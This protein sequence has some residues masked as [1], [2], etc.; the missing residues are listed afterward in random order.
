MTRLVDR[1][2]DHPAVAIWGVNLGPS[3]EN[4]YGIPYV[5]TMF[6]QNAPEIDFRTAMTDY[7]ELAKENF[8][9]WLED[10]YGNINKLNNAWETDY[11]SFDE[12]VLPQPIQTSAQDT[13][14]KNGDS[15]SSMLDWQQFRYDMLLDEWKFI[16]NV[17]KELDPNKAILG[18]P[19]WNPTWKQ[20]GTE[21]MCGTAEYVVESNLTEIHRANWNIVPSDNLKFNGEG[22]PGTGTDY[23]NYIEY[24]RKN[25]TP[26]IVV[27]ENWF[28][29]GFGND[30][31][32][33]RSLEVRDY[34]RDN[35]GYMWFVVS[36]SFDNNKPNW[37]WEN[38]K[39]VVENSKVNEFENLT[40]KNP[41]LLFYY[42][43]K[44]LMSHYYEEKDDMRSN[45][46]YYAISEALF[47]ANDKKL[48]NS[49]ISAT[50][51]SK[52]ALSYP[53]AKVL[54]MANQRVISEDVLKELKKFIADGGKIILIGSNGV[55]NEDF[56]KDTTVIEELSGLDDEQI[57]ERFYTWGLAEDAK[58]PIISVT[59][60]GTEYAE[61]PFY[62]E[63]KEN[64]SIFIKAIGNSLGL[65]SDGELV[66]GE[67]TLENTGKCGDNVCDENET[68]NIG[69]CPQDCKEST[70]MGAVNLSSNSDQGK[71]G[72]GICDEY[73][74]Q[75][76]QVCP[77]DCD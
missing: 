50:Q 61:I 75:N 26:F 23:A 63:A 68:K 35:G 25:N 49:F 8:H 37:S 43:M 9:I 3:G 70:E 72:D 39:E 1:Y 31:P 56:E 57:I 19:G 55:F 15:R 53:E 29:R 52:S 2:K 17:V 30:I 48:Q 18:D 22:T 59:K 58:M 71:C 4:G 16:V 10:K 21:N 45:E 42:D 73:E 46:I 6:D 32:L 38:V 44:G 65:S 62:G 33:E 77:Q 76:S 34:I 67:K 24:S 47:N 7:S 27:L 20:T 41:E 74:T 51:I 54:V 28:T 60:S 11:S 14:D 5:A 13:F 69:L 12:V 66:F 64:Y 36:L 40:V